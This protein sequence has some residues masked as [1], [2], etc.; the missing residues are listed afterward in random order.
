MQWA[1]E[2]TPGTMV[3]V[4]GLDVD[5]VDEACAEARRTIEGSFVTVANDNSTSPAQVVI[6]GDPAG[7]AFVSEKCTGAGARRVVPLV[8]GG[9]FHSQAMAPAQEGLARAVAM[10]VIGEARVPIVANVTARPIRRQRE[11]RAELSEQVTSRVRWAD[12]MATLGASGCTRF[13]EFGAG[14]VLSGLVQRAIPGAQAIQV[15]DAEGVG[16]AVDWLSK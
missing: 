1:G 10:A 8:V 6:A 9:A 2:M 12:T 3:A 15:A 5:T 14:A 11:I 7:I 4:L 13:V 16:R